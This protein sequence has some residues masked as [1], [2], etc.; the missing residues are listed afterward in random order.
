[1]HENSLFA[2]LLRS[3]WWISFAVALGLFLLVRLFIPEAYA[4]VVPIPFVVIGCIAAW[5][6]L[7]VPG[8][9]QI[10]ERLEALRA[11]PWR[12]FA[13][14]LEAAYQREGYAV[15]RLNAGAAD[16][17]LTRDARRTLVSAKR[18]KVARAGIEPLRELAAAGGADA[19]AERI[20]IAAG[21]L[22]AQA[23]AFAASNGIRIVEGAE[24]A[25]L[26]AHRVQSLNR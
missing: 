17:E 20:F 7:R 15:R 10:A 4:I 23:R 16:F 2:L 5:R 21:E 12:D 11:M 9:R 26:L 14:T 25:A 3:R 13:A 6:Q 22:T 1:M 8:A 24:L 18:W 19:V